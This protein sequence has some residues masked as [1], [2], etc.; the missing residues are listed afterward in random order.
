[1]TVHEHPSRTHEL[2]ADRCWTLLERREIGRVGFA[3]GSEQVILPVNYVIDGRSIVIRT[4]FSSLLDALGAGATVAFEVDDV[5]SDFRTG[6]SVLLKGYAAE[7]TD[8]TERAAVATL[9]LQPWVGG[10]R[11]RWLRIVPWS[12]SGRA[13]SR[14]RDQG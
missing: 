6:W 9:P 1:M 8:A 10:E 13:I 14:Q 12:V 11:D 3:E 4:G 5:D 7:V 2:D